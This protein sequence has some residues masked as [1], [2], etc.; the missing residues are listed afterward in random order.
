MKSK[1]FIKEISRHCVLVQGVN[2]FVTVE[3]SS[4]EGLKSLYAQSYE[5]VESQ[6]EMFMMMTGGQ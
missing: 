1:N 5:W 2:F 6:N 3:N 4:A